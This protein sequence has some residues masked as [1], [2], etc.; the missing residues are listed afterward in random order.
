M[1]PM[2]RR[3]AMR[4]QLGV[5]QK[6][7]ELELPDGNVVEV[8]RSPIAPP[9][10]D[11]SDAD[12]QALETPHRFPSLRLALT[13]DDHIAIAVDEHL[14]HLPEILVP[15]LEYIRSAGI[16]PEAIT[17]ICQPPST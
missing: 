5:G 15:L 9:V 8:R 12:R 17:L 13:P 2:F 11:I 14:P 4:C 10:A 16:A 1:P 7:V 3:E 6:T